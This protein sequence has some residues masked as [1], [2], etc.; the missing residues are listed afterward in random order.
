M[1][2]ST[3][4][5]VGTYLIIICILSQ[6]CLSLNMLHYFFKF[7]LKFVLDLHDWDKLCLIINDFKCSVFSRYF[8]KKDK[9]LTSYLFPIS[10]LFFSPPLFFPP[11]LLFPVIFSLPLS[12]FL[13]LSLSLLFSPLLFIPLL[14][15]PSS[16]PNC[17]L[18]FWCALVRFGC[19]GLYFIN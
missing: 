18:C 19:Q 3:V 11:I 9:Q 1:L 13:F 15:P 5:L 2:N 7:F 10:S 8:H 12:S 4:F 16:A 17:I 14:F 6:D